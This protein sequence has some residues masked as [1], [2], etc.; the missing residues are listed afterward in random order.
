MII[1]S[2]MTRDRVIGN[3]AG[4]A[5]PWDIPEEYNKFLGFIR[6]QTVIMGRKS[7]EIFKGDMSRSTTF[8]VSRSQVSYPDATVCRSLDE[9]VEKAQTTGREIYIA[10]GGTIYQQALPLVDKMYL[11]YI[12]GDYRG[13]TFFPVFDEAAWHITYRE[14]HPRFEFVVYERLAP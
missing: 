2:A 13:N 5:M 4:D 10:G 8:V 12:K 11:S 3:E 1:I 14:D 7:F 9:A 6:D